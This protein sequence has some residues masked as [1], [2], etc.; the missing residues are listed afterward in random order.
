MTK[1]T[2]WFVGVCVCVLGW[3]GRE[4][5]LAVQPGRW[6]H[7]SEA[8]YESGKK[9]ATVVTNLGDVKLAAGTNARASLPEDSSIVYDLQPLGQ[10]VYLAAGPEGLLLKLEGDQTT[11]LARLE[12]EQVFC[13]DVSKDGQLLLGVSGEKSRVD[14]LTPEGLKTVVELPTVRYVWDLRVRGDE[15]FVASGTEGKVWRVDLSKADGAAVTEILDA[16]Q[17]NVICLD[18]DAQGNLYAGTDTDGLVYRLTPGAAGFTSFVIYDAAEP[19]IGALLVLPDGTVYAGT[20]DAEQAKPGRLEEAAKEQQGRPEE[21]AEAPA[22]DGAEPPA[23]PAPPE[24]PNVPPDAEPR[25]DLPA[26]PSGRSDPMPG[27]SEPGVALN[28][29][30]PPTVALNAEPA[31]ADHLSEEPEPSPVTPEQRDRLR[32]AIRS[33][34]LKARQ[35]GSVQGLGPGQAGFAGGRTTPA[36][37]PGTARPTPTPAAPAKEGNAIYRINPDGFVT[38]VFRESVM[39]LRLLPDPSHPQRLLVATG[40][41][42]QLFRIDPA[43]EETTIL[44]DLEPQQIPALSVQRIGDQSRVLLGTANPASVVELSQGFAAQGT[45]TSAALDATQISLWGKAQ[46]VAVSPAN[47]QLFFE[48]RSGNVQDPEE[49]AWSPWSPPRPVPPPAE[50]LSPVELPIE[51]PPA[52]F[53]QYR[54][55]LRS[56]GSESP[57]V[58]RVELSYVVPN[59]KPTISALKVSNPF[60]TTGK[61]PVAAP[62][63]GTPD[64]PRTPNRTIEWEA[65]DPNNDGLSYTIEYQ[66][67]GSD[68]W[69]PLAENLTALTFEWNTLR[70]P[71]GRYLLRVIASDAPGNTPD[72]ARTSTRQSD[73]V[74]IDNAPPQVKDLRPEV[75]GRAIRLTGSAVD[76]HSPI[77]EV[78][79]MVN[80]KEPWRAVLPTD[81]IF[82]STS[83]SFEVSID[84]L[85]AELKPGK[86][87]VTL[88]VSDAQQNVTYQSVVV[89]IQP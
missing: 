28:L 46:L 13:L 62:A 60:D 82:D 33:Q 58:D 34:L 43:A 68:A 29:V 44:T 84:G 59:L 76:A 49:A 36:P 14:M 53:L 37:P 75:R 77:R 63:P 71:D 16:K 50:A 51:A 19:E 88:R 86:Q 80:G 21:P 3:Q 41:E 17:A 54:L 10:T 73:P 85:A 26:S 18:S 1:N 30:T 42:G 4:P 52:R 15:L 72:M 74:L 64:Q 56:D 23:A 78:Q 65:A 9:D 70:V 8:D 11:E 6:T 22:Q 2:F 35:T 5:A 66:L 47:T 39:I 61:P 81:L 45:M 38:E 69:L 40:S 67:A 7:T 12:G 48:T 25:E 24:I 27:A 87:V 31:D 89:E 57:V 55:T 20:A 79:V 83:E 32:E